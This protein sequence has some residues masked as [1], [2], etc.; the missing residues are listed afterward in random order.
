VHGT[1]ASHATAF[2]ACHGIII[3][4]I[5]NILIKDMLKDIVYEAEVQERR[6]AKIPKKT[7]L[8]TCAVEGEGSG[9]DHLENFRNLCLFYKCESFLPLDASAERGYEIAC[10]LSVRLSVCLKR[11][12]TVFK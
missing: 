11:L 2:P 9:A 5:Q 4:I 7:V 8:S 6:S 1:V 3:I 12:G 10:R